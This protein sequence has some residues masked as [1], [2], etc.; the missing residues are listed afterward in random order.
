MLNTESEKRPEITDI[1]SMPIML[2]YI[3]M[4]L[5]RQLTY[6]KSNVTKEREVEIKL[7][8]TKR[9]SYESL[10]LNLDYISLPKSQ[11]SEKI[12]ITTSD[13]ISVYKIS[14]GHS[15]KNSSSRLTTE[16]ISNKGSKS[17]ESNKVLKE[18]KNSDFTKI[19]KLKKYLENFLG[20]DNFLEIYFK[21]NVI[22]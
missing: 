8:E 21:T 16:N 14:S 5:I 6:K 13:E 1:L 7:E 10:N 20:L 4:N 9:E 18:D 2:K 15:S 12:N 11:N 17:I 19:E 22:R 3:K